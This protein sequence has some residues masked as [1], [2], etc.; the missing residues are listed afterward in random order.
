MLLAARA[1]ILSSGCH[2]HPAHRAAP[3]SHRAIEPLIWRRQDRTEE[4]YATL[5]GM[6]NTSE[7]E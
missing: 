2:E 3:F 6:L 4:F 7:K 5:T 1:A